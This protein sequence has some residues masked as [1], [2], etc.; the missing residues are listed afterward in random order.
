MTA[1]NPPVFD[2]GLVDR[3]KGILL[4]PKYEWPII[5]AEQRAVK[6]LFRRYAMILAAIGPVAT[7]VSDLVFDDKGILSVLI[8]GFVSYGLNLLAA[9]ILGIVIDGVAHNFGSEKNIV[10]SMKLAVYAM[11]P[12]W[13][14]GILNLIQGDAP[15]VIS[16]LVGLYGAYLVYCGL[17]PLKHTPQD[18]Q[19]VYTIVLVIVW[20]LL[21]MVVAGLIM[22]VFMAFSVIGEGAMAFAID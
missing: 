3:V 11:T 15:A 14:L 20:G 8:Y 21:T 12:F 6:S 2:P 16:L 7:I 4:R 19:L 17:G 5:A 1:E 9:Y 18:K 22:A 10:Q 13:L